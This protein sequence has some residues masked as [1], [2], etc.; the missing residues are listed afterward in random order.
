VQRPAAIVVLLALPLLAACGGS[1]TPSTAPTTTAVVSTTAPTAI[2]TSTP[3]P[4]PTP[5][6]TSGVVLDDAGA[7]PRASI[8]PHPRAGTSTT[9]MTMDM[10]ISVDANGKHQSLAVTMGM[11][12]TI[13]VSHASSTGTAVR[14]TYGAPTVTSG[15]LKGAALRKMRAQMGTLRGLSATGSLKADGTWSSFTM[16]APAGLD[17]QVASTFKQMGD[18][19][20]KGLLQPV[21]A[22]PVGA[23]AR[24]TVTQ[25]VVVSGIQTTTRSTYTLVSRHG[26]VIDATTTG[27]I[28]GDGTINSGGQSVTVDASGPT[29]G[30]TRFSLLQLAPIHGDGSSDETLHLKGSDGSEMT[31][32]MAMRV[33]FGPR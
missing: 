18:G 5:G 27:T 6:C 22:D 4:T 28:S 19:L 10:K 16:R 26:D 11:P 9:A 24:W 3:A 14:A 1:S 20:Q 7:A 23:G 15:T 8:V 30:T 25:C 29:T 17:P 21:P 32:E 2:A 33:R 31:M 12:L 13:T